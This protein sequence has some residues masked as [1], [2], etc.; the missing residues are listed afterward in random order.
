[1]RRSAL[2]Q[3]DL[4][5]RALHIQNSPLLSG[6]QLAAAYVD[7]TAGQLHLLSN[8]GCRAVVATHRDREH[9]VVSHELG[10]PS[11]EDTAAAVEMSS[12]TGS[13]RRLAARAAAQR[14]VFTTGG[15]LGPNS[16]VSVPITGDLESV[17]LGSSGLW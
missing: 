14:G 16:I 8:G 11:P 9:L 12:L 1:M 3:L 13:Q 7:L 10:R 15:P 2:A 5:F 6:T 17:V 4:K